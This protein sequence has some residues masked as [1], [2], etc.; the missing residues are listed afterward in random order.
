MSPRLMTMDD[1]AKEAGLEV[2]Q[3]RFLTSVLS[4]F[5]GGDNA[6]FDDEELDRLKFVKDLTENRCYT[7]EEVQRELEVNPNPHSMH[8][9][10][11]SF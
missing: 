10:G 6:G 4:R 3:V 1:I 5:F 8:R 11:G 2:S 9:A 7:I